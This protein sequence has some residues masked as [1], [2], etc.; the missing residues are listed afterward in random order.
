MQFVSFFDEIAVSLMLNCHMSAATQIAVVVEL[1]S[2][3]E[4][5]TKEEGAPL[6]CKGRQK[7]TEEIHN[8]SNHCQNEVRLSAKYEI[9]EHDTHAVHWQSVRK[10]RQNGRCLQRSYIEQYHYRRSW[11]LYLLHLARVLGSARARG[12][13]QHQI[14]RAITS[15]NSARKL[16][17]LT[18]GSQATATKPFPTR[19]WNNQSAGAVQTR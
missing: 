19:N 16:K 17:Q 8:W 13:C 11:L 12:C 15:C 7:H 10:I 18:S 9:G 6:I 2:T 4:S 5:P 1:V 3:I 14:Q